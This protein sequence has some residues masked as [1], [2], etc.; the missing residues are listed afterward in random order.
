MSRERQEFIQ[1]SEEQPMVND[2][3]FNIFINSV[4]IW[5]IENYLSL[6]KQ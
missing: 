4:L 3:N 2:V 5:R 6:V 1:R